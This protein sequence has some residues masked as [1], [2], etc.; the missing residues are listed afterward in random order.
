[1][2]I[3]LIVKTFS[4]TGLRYF[5][6]DSDFKIY[7]ERLLNGIVDRRY[8]I[9]HEVRN[10]RESPKSTRMPPLGT[11]GVDPRKEPR[12][13]DG[14][15]RSRESVTPSVD[16]A[17]SYYFFLASTFDEKL[18]Y[19]V[20]QLCPYR[21]AHRLSKKNLPRSREQNNRVAGGP[22]PSCKKIA[23]QNRKTYHPRSLRVGEESGSH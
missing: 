7:R 23:Q 20:G 1:M 14:P 18:F 10:Q 15:N 3:I 22:S 9:A 8:S 4:E 5:E 2:Q 21:Q 11:R 17:L 19:K 12:S 6:K 13:V 16:P